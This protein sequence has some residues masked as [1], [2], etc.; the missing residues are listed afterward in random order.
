MERFTAELAGP[1]QSTGSVD[2]VSRFRAQRMV[3]RLLLVMALVSVIPGCALGVMAGKMFFGDPRQQCV[4]HQA[5][6]V[7]LTKGEKKLLM[8]CST[9][10]SLQSQYPTLQVDLIDRISL[11]LESRNINIISG[12]EVAA[13]Y[14][15][16]GSWGD[17]LELTREFDA[18][19]LALVDVKSFS[20]RV[21]NSETLLQGTCTGTVTIF[22]VKDS[23]MADMAIHPFDIMYPTN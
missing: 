22:Q 9:P 10:H 14:D 20:E 21:P 6:G 8:I 13:W 16:H 15:D 3:S 19:Y 12:D 1:V 7:D 2:A 4:F 23:G 18:D 17:Y 5:T 11:T